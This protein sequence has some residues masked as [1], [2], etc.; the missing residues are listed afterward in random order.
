MGQSEYEAKH[1]TAEIGRELDIRRGINKA[2]FV[3]L[4][5]E[6]MVLMLMFLM[7]ILNIFELQYQKICR[8]ADGANCSLLQKTAGRIRSFRELLLPV[9]SILLNSQENILNVLLTLGTI[10][11]AAVIFFYSVQDN[12]KEGIPNRMIMSYTSGSLTVPVLFMSLMFLIPVNYAAVSMELHYFAWTGMIF[13]YITQ[14]LILWII[15]KSTSHSYS[16]HAI[17]NAEIC[18]YQ[19]LVEIEKRLQGMENTE[20]EY[21]FLW[22]YLLQH[23]EQALLSDEIATDKLELARRLIRVPWYE[24]KISFWEEPLWS[25]QKYF[26]KKQKS[27]GANPELSPG[28]LKEEHLKSLYEFYYRNL[29]TVLQYMGPQEYREE[30]N[31]IYLVFYEFLEELTA[32]YERESAS[33]VKTAEA[34]NGMEIT[35]GGSQRE[36]AEACES[37]QCYVM[38]VCGILNAVADSHVT[39][40]EEVCNYVFNHVISR[41]VWK[42]QI[43]LYF[44]FQGYLSWI[45]ADTARIEKLDEIEGIESWNIGKIS[46]QQMDECQKFWRIWIRDTSLPEGKINNFFV[47]VVKTLAEDGHKPDQIEYIRLELTNI[48]GEHI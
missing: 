9:K 5:V 46:E 2:N 37:Y 33:G 27:M 18:Q 12:R 10:L 42:M 23:L 47:K 31:K 44:L 21:A 11:A 26:G 7:D 15:L 1:L 20:R 17:C 6:A 41:K 39:E 19:K 48:R 4:L 16:V 22:T 38:T 24:K 30:R 8:I 34:G 45:N 29:I 43:F 3:Y 36:T 32:V 28:R 14:I 13:T 40:A 25:L 35:E